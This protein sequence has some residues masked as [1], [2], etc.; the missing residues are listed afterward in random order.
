MQII[1]TKAAVEA[2]A[3]KTQKVTDKLNKTA[4][5]FRANMET[6]GDMRSEKADELRNNLNDDSVTRDKNAVKTQETHAT[7]NKRLAGMSTQ[8]SNLVFKYKI[9]AKVIESQSRE[10][11]K[12]TIGLLEA[13]ANND[14]SYLDNG[15]NAFGHYLKAK[16]LDNVTTADFQRE[17][18]HATGTQST[19]CKNAFLFLGMIQ[20]APKVATGK[21]IFDFDADSELLTAYVALFK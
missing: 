3:T 20:K 16:G 12:R 11:K 2:I 1:D 6:F 14:P 4:Q 10:L 7:W 18:Q 15:L 21:W 17:A 9:D 13:I 8:A 19:Y 5:S